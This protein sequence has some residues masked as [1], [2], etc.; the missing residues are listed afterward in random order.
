MLLIVV[1]VNILE[2][3]ISGK[4]AVGKPRI[5]YLKQISRNTGADSY[6]VMNRMAC[7][8]YSWEAAKRSKD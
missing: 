8:N 1:V 5:Q 2:G 3:E 4:K 6:T 7:N